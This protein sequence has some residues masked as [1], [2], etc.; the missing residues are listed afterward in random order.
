MIALTSPPL[1]ARRDDERGGAE[2]DGRCDGGDQ[3]IA[4]VHGGTGL[5]QAFDD[6]DHLGLARADRA[7]DAGDFVDSFEERA[8]RRGGHRLDGV[9]AA[10]H[11]PLHSRDREP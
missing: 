11:V 3:S 7:V 8:E 6:R 9:E 1:R 10:R 5:E 2:R 4:E